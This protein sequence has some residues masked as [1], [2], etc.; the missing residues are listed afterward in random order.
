[1]QPLGQNEIQSPAGD[2]AD[3]HTSVNTGLSGFF[4]VTG[5]F[6]RM[7]RRQTRALAIVTP[8]QLVRSRGLKVF[9]VGLL[10]VGASG[11]WVANDGHGGVTA[12]IAS[13]AGLQIDK[14]IVNGNR[15]LNVNALQASF[16][17][18]LGG[19][20]F[21]FNVNEA[22]EQVM[23]SPWVEAATIRKYFPDTVVVDLVERK[24]VALWKSSGIVNMISAAGDVIA[25][26]DVRHLGLPQV[27]GEGANTSAAEFLTEIA[28][29][30]ELTS[31]AKAYIRVG[32]RRWNIAL[33]DGPSILLP[34]HN[35]RRALADINQLQHG[36]RLLDRDI[37]Q[38]DMR[39]ADRLVIKMDPET[40]ETRK[41][42]IRKALKRDWHKT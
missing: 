11:Y 23:A 17:D 33:G 4:G 42:V 21:N 28:N 5:F 1:M 2:N 41:T 36:K 12:S 9:V 13:K 6:K 40:A 27:V 22:R 18:Q 30:P 31:R 29:Y 34:E 37:V 16:A 25:E 32:Q 14:L 7:W 8:M 39:L 38:V 20:Y 15:N 35:W 10:A 26:A 19:S 3:V 24:P